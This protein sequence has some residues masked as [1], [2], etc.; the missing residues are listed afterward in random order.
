[1]SLSMSECGLAFCGKDRGIEKPPDCLEN[2]MNG[3]AI[4]HHH[5]CHID[6]IVKG[7]GIVM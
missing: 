3:F 2:M 6:G 7:I 4:H 5:I 1:M